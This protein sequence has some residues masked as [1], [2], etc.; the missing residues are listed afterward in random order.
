MNRDRHERRGTAQGRRL[1][2]PVI[3]SL[4]AAV[5]L[6][7]CGAEAPA[8]SMSPAPAP[9]AA[10]QP[11]EQGDDAFE[12]RLVELRAGFDAAPKTFGGVAGTPEFSAMSA[13]LRTMSNQA[14]DVHLRANAALL[15]GL[16]HQEREQWAE[17]AGAYRR[18]AALVPDDAGP[19]M[20]LARALAGTDDYVAAAKAQA[21]AV[22]RDPDNL[23]QYLA[24]GEL[25]L[26]A[27]D[28]D[29]SA[30]AY[31][32]YEVR[33]RELID[34]LTLRRDGAYLV[35]ADE[36]IACAESLA[37]AS[38]VG[39]AFALLYALQQEPDAPVRAA[40]V[41][42]MGVQRLLG[43]EPRLT[44]QLVKETDS[45]VKEAIAWALA[46]IARAPVDTKLDGPPPEG[47]LGQS[48]AGA[49]TGA[50][51]SAPAAT[52]ARG[53]GSDPGAPPPAAPPGHDAPAEAAGSTASAP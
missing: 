34:G 9:A 7:A 31:A 2:E 47:T 25:H 19:H 24:L 44:A 50:P 36:R 46:E 6:A 51:T 35:G 28:K 16:L 32:D 3:G 8:V 20:A 29:A 37:S 26:R 49:P 42:A 39:T 48:P 12:K 18:A 45:E 53:G 13:E 30:K 52:P 40:I 41:R 11:A 5:L 23:E 21:D 14:H 43:Y 1:L 27:G 38:D 4:L 22:T 10:Q 17:A 33:R 15:L